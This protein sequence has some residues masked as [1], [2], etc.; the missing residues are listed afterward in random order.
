MRDLIESILPRTY[1]SELDEEYGIVD[2]EEIVEALDLEADKH[3]FSATNV[4]LQ[5]KHA[6]MHVEGSLGIFAAYA[7]MCVEIGD[8][9]DWRSEDHALRPCSLRTFSKRIASLH[10][11]EDGSTDLD[12]RLLAVAA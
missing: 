10:H 3:C 12:A 4:A 8:L 2:V 5:K 1:L 6:M 11:H 9:N 7:E